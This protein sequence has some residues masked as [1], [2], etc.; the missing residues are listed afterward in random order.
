MKK[1]TIGF[2]R[3]KGN[4]FPILSWIIRL[5]QG[6]TPYSHVYLKFHLKPIN[7][8]IIYQASSLQVNYINP[9]IFNKKS[10]IVEEFKFDITDEDYLDLLVYTTKHV[11]KPYG[12]KNLFAILL[13]KESWGDEDK[14]FICSELVVPILK[15][16][17]G[18]SIDKKQDLITPKDL[19]KILKS[20]PLN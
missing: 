5:Y 7:E 2:S 10:H 14:S 19:Y 16:I 6:W 17:V 9:N 13:K 3:P 1:I 4:I 15:N 11:G 8:E 20:L 18:I 12:I